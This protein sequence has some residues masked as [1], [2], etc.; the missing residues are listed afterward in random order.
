MVVPLF[1]HLISAVW[2]A[3]SLCKKGHPSAMSEFRESANRPFRVVARIQDVG[4]QTNDQRF[5][6]AGGS[7]SQRVTEILPGGGGGGQILV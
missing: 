7:S 3:S 2:P 1:S 4:P 6:Q 5:E